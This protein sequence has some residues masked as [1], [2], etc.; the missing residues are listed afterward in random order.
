VHPVVIIWG[1][2]TADVS[3]ERGVRSI[4]G[5]TVVVGRQAERWL[6][7]LPV[8]VLAESQ[9]EAV[10][11]LLDKYVE[12]RDPRED[13]TA[14]VPHSVTTLVLQSGMAFVSAIFGLLVALELVRLPGPTWSTL[15]TLAATILVSAGLVRWNRIPRF[16]SL[17]WLA[18]VVSGSLFVAAFVIAHQVGVT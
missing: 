16:L 4:A 17:G 8:G 10:W 5:A 6:T 11:A 18:G 12:R 14:P 1:T 13:E 3:P 15:L 2:G 7:S 9:I